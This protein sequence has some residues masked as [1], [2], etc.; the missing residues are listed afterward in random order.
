MNNIEELALT[1]HELLMKEL[2]GLMIEVRADGPTVHDVNYITTTFLF[3]RDG[4]RIQ[5][6]IRFSEKE[7]R[8][9]KDLEGF[10]KQVALSV[11]ATMGRYIF[12][13]HKD[14]EVAGARHLVNPENPEIHLYE[15]RIS[16]GE[17]DEVG[18]CIAENK[19]H[20]MHLFRDNLYRSYGEDWTG[21]IDID[22]ID[23][24]VT[25]YH[26]MI[27]KPTQKGLNND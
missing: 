27:V 5:H 3:Y 8:Y 2:E 10:I 25:G 4:M 26:S 9:Q 18:V 7:L 6:R 19:R 23:K 14:L 16:G 24:R 21:T 17:C 22:E 12:S 15:V 1:V 13:T 20:A 11:S